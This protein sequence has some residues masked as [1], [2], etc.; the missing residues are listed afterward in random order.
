MVHVQPDENRSKEA[1]VH[2]QLHNMQYECNI[3]RVAIKDWCI[4]CQMHCQK[5]RWVGPKGRNFLEAYWTIF[6]QQLGHVLM[7]ILKSKNYEKFALINRWDKNEAFQC[8]GPG[9]PSKGLWDLSQKIL[10]IMSQSHACFCISDS[11][12]SF[13]QR[14]EELLETLRTILGCKLLPKFCNTVILGTV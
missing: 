10:C 7:R 2:A 3:Q 11:I 12:Q 9:I 14:K 1:K 8:L 6:C 4:E 5:T 13:L